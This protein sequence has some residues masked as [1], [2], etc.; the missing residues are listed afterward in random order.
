LKKIRKD[1]I[2]GQLF[3]IKQIYL[4]ESEDFDDNEIR[5]EILALLS[6][7]HDHIIKY[8]KS[9]VTNESE[10]NRPVLSIFMD[11]CKY[12]SLRQIIDRYGAIPENLVK[13]IAWE[14]LTA[15]NYLHQQG[16][17]HCDLKAA[18]VLVDEKGRIKIGDFGVS[19]NP[20]TSNYPIVS[21]VGSP[22]WM[23]PELITKFQQK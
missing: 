17:G 22:Y 20:F 23:A 6:C 7:D 14:I 12:G 15:L 1:K 21:L 18:N 3:A 4:D 16:I 10:S 5:S 8:H 19:I 2:T 13:D 11:Y 9:S